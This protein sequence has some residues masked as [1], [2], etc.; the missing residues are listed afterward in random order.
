MP[1][2]AS[3]RGG[4]LWSQKPTSFHVAHSVT[5]LLSGMPG[6]S[7]RKVCDVKLRAF[8]RRMVPRWARLAGAGPARGATRPALSALVLR[9]AG[10]PAPHGGRPDSD[11]TAA[12]PSSMWCGV[13]RK[14]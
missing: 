13:A 11:L 4:Y 9:L 3:N 12:R 5:T 1:L 8:V 10:Y 6:M 7:M 14:P 2:S